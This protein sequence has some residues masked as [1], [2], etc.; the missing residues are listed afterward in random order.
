MSINV[1]AGVLAVQFGGRRQYATAEAFAEDGLLSGLFTDFCAGQGL[2]HVASA[3]SMIP[4]LGERVDLTNRRPSARVLR[5]T[6]SFPS[7]LFEI[8]RAAALGDGMLRLKALVAAHDAANDRMF[9]S[10]FG[11]ATH[12]VTQF[13]EAVA[14]QRKARDGGLFVATDMNIAPSTEEI[15][16]QEQARFPDWEAPSLYFGQTLAERDGWQRP[17]TLLDPV[18]DLYLCPSPFVQGDLIQNFGVSADRTRLVPYEVN[19]KWFGVQNKPEPG[20][21]LFAGGV[22]LRKGIHVLAACAR[23]LRSRKRPIQIFVAG[24]VPV[25]IRSRPECAAL[26]F[27]GR[28]LGPDMM[29]EYEKADIFVLP[30]LAEGSASVAYEALGCGI[31]VVT[32]WESGTVVRHG[33]NGLIVPVRNAEAVA[34]GLDTLIS[35]RD[36][37]KKMS[38]QAHL[39]ARLHDWVRYGYKLRTALLEAPK[40]A[41]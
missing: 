23:I 39:A 12:L 36:L 13:G 28:L 30:S 40:K 10:G 27:L 31:P 17:M 14:L 7:W 1:S 2:G 15:V 20:R 24:H 41:V 35:D 22:G 19:P 8:R 25:S 6:K 37:R 4:G 16:R 29:K 11:D 32:T 9:R 3:L 38:R 33:I 21:V 34:E 26:V 18:T 5:K